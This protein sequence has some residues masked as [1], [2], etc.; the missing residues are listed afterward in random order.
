MAE[1]RPPE[2]Q[3]G[4]YPSKDITPILR[5][6]EHE[7]GTINVRRI[8]GLDGQPKLQMRLDLGLMQMELDGRPD[9]R[10]PHGCESL[11]DYFEKRLR[12]YRRKNGTELGFHLT[13]NQCQALREEALMY[14]HRYLGLF[15]LREYIGVARDTNRNLRVLDLCGKFAVDDQDR[16]ILEQYRPYILMMHTRALA[17]IEYNSGNY[18]PALAIVKKGLRDLKSFFHRF[19]Q[20]EAYRHA[21]EVRLLK[22]FGREIRDKLPIDPMEKLNR[23]LNRAIKFERYEDA[24]RI[25][26]EIERLNPPQQQA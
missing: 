9:G 3:Y 25:R 10:R 15:V 2:R 7:S 14:Y 12:E 17:S 23:E 8:I 26:D 19:G 6:W 18:A 1:N 21:S 11:L 20:D 16:L 13:P 5:G 24:A 22:R 4:R